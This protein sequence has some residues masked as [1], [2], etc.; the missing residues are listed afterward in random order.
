MAF[1]LRSHLD[2]NLGG[3][4]S[5]A[6]YTG[7]VGTK[8]LIEQYIEEVAFDLKFLSE[9]TIPLMSNEV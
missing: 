6:L 4:A 8:D 5:P 9:Q 3:M 2:R 7:L 1:C